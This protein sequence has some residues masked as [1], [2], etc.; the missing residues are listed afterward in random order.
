MNQEVKN[1][2]SAYRQ[3]RPQIKKRLADFK[4]VY[5]KSPARWFEELCFCLCT[6]Q[7]KAV[8]CGQAI[9][10][11][12]ATKILFKG[13]A[14]RIACHLKGLV[15]FHNNKSRYI[16]EARKIFYKN[17]RFNI[18]DRIRSFS[19]EK[20]ARK[21][22][23]E[24]IKGISLKEASHFLRNTGLGCDLAIIDRHVLTN[25]KRY[26]A[27]K[28]IPSHIS[29]KKYLQL[30]EACRRFSKRTGIPLAELDLLFWSNQT[31]H[32]FK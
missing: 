15:R 17:N 25:L 31:G 27:I 19:D 18:K 13:P 29:D 4:A 2:L 5:A 21:W 26:G 8:K 32:I 9:N 24:N 1:L 16:A 23:V 11:L 10:R 3:K 6:P 14:A 28:E 20:K 12:K 30:E 22:L 7:S